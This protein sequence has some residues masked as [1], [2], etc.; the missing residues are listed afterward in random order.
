M[1]AL[2]PIAL[3]ACGVHTDKAVAKAAVNVSTESQRQDSFE[4]TAQ[5]LDEKPQLVDELYTVMRLHPKSLDRFM[6][7][8]STD[9]DQKW[10]A[11]NMAG[12]LAKNPAGLEEVM[13]AAIPTI[14]KEP[15]ARVALNKS[16][17]ASS[18]QTADILTDDAQAMAKVV[19]S[20]LAVTEKKPAARKNLITAVH[21]DREAIV[22]FVRQDKALARAIAVEVLRESVKDKPTLEKVLGMT[23]ALDTP[24]GAPEP[25]APEKAKAP[26]KPVA[27]ATPPAGGGPTPAPVLGK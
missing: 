4:A 6:A 19:K 9:L 23:G 8:A 10:I 18:D 21:A 7:N 15:K 14:A 24:K 25:A 20:L 26:A 16:L 5:L 12:Y 13:N 17:A 1:L 11:K 3:A 2:S 22:A 27:P